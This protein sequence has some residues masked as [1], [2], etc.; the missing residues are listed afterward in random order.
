[1]TAAEKKCPGPPRVG[2]ELT[3]GIAGVRRSR[4]IC[5][6]VSAPKGPSVDQ[7]E[8]DDVHDLWRRVPF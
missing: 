3:R 5:L 4:E 1:M 8:V 2:A 7:G 6:P